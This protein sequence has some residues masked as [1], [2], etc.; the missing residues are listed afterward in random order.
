MFVKLSRVRKENAKYTRKGFYYPATINRFNFHIIL[1]WN[2][3]YKFKARDFKNKLYNSNDEV[4]S[5][6]GVADNE[7]QVY[8]YYKDLV[9]SERKYVVALTPVYRKYEY[10]YGGWRW[11]KWGQ[12]I[13]EKELKV[14]YLY[15]EKD[16]DL[17]YCFHL[18]EILD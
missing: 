14:E 3:R 7:D 4:L 12:Y 5:W 16:I 18:Y 10:P 17:I 2:C 9:N 15:D 11:R 8:E 6:Y 1:K 13:G